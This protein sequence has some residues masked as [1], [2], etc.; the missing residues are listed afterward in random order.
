MEAGKLIIEV[1]AGLIPGQPMEE[2][3]RRWGFTAR[4]WDE[5]HSEDKDVAKEALD[6]W[7][8]V[9]GWAREYA[10]RLQNPHTVNWVRMDWIW[11]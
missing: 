6:A 4:E 2:F 1:Q 7:D 10:A 11:L 8:R 3:T 9:H 5:M